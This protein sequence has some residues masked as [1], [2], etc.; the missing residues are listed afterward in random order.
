MVHWLP[1]FACTK[2]E[3]VHTAADGG[4]FELKELTCEEI[5]KRLECA[6]ALTM[7]D[8][9]SRHEQLE[10]I[11]VMDLEML[12]SQFIKAVKDTPQDD[13]AVWDFIMKV[14]TY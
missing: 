2:C 7:V 14:I 12:R 5:G 11:K 10:W 13:P 9:I 3:T 8:S 6:L 1:S 4:F